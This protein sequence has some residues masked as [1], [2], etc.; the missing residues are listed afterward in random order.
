MFMV[1]CMMGR[2]GSFLS[3]NGKPFLSLPN[4]YA[5]SINIDWFQPYERTQHSEGVIYM[6]VMN[7]PR[8]ERFLQENIV[9]IGVIP[10][11][12]EPSLTINSYLRPLVDE[13]KKLWHGVRLR[14]SEDVGVLVRAALLCV[15]C[16]IPAAR[17]TCG[18]LSHMATKGCS[19]CQISFPTEAFGEK[20]DYSNFDRSSWEPRTGSMHKSTALEHQKCTTRTKQLGIERDTGVRYSVLVELPYFDAPKMCIIDPMHN[21]LLGTAKHMVELWKNLGLLTDK[22]FVTIQER[23]DSFTA[24]SDVGR[25]PTKISSAFSGFT[26]EQWKNFTVFFSLF[27]LKGILPPSHYNCW[28]LFVKATYLFCRRTIT[29]DQI[30]EADTY[31]MMFCNRFRD[32]YHQRACTINMH[33]HGHLMEC[34]KNYGPVYSFWLFAFERLNGIMGSYHTN[35]HNISLQFARR[36]FASNEFAP[37]NW[38]HEFL[39]DFYPLLKQFKYQKGSLGQESFELVAKSTELTCI[40]LLPIRESAFLDSEIESLKPIVGDGLIRL[41][42]K[43]TAIRLGRFVLGAKGS[44]HSNSSLL[45]AKRSGDVCLAEVLFFVRCTVFT[46]EEHSYKWVAA[47]AWF[48][49]HPCKVWFG[50]PCQV[51]S[52]ATWPGFSFVSVQDIVSRVVHTKSTVNFGRFIG[53]QTVL[54]VVPLDV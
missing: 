45:L 40:P 42:E 39:H 29:R 5:F 37:C 43:S 35:G 49:E 20:P 28:H 19:K 21:L 3:Y 10:G 38:P 31:I 4:N 12:H 23:V 36:F 32:L 6:S 30:E 22:D 11:P 47:V 25:I 53:N 33:L 14:T 54:V 46:N 16:D 2:F 17:K 41:N 51:W 50:S 26:A 52:S 34:I 24:L 1:M 27:A 7:L 9:L 44:R 13:L 15:A 8:T 48:I 18:F